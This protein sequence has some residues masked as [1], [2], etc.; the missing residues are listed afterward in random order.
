MVFTLLSKECIL[1]LITKVGG[2]ILMKKK[3]IS[4]LVIMVMLASLLSNTRTIQ[5]KKFIAN[6]KEPI[7]FIC[8][9][10]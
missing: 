8:D 5:T 10:S 6:E 7:I 4:L 9:R 1:L 3:V 2:D